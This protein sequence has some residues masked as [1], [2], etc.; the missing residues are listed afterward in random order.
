LRRAMLISGGDL[1]IL[2]TRPISL[3]LLLLGLGLLFFL[4]LPVFRHTRAVAFE[5][6]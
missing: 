4:A 3:T 1:S 6:N 5:K 2:V